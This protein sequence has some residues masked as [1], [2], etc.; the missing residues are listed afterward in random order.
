MILF[1]VRH[2]DPIYNP[3]S[4][5][6]L[7]H[8]QAKALAKRLM[9]HGVDEVY[10]S[11][12]VRATQTA[13]PTAK[14]LKKE[15]HPCE[16][17][18]ESVAWRGFATKNDKGVNTWCF[19]IPKYVELFNTAEIR[20]MGQE[21]HTHPAFA[22]TNFTNGVLNTNQSVDDFLLSLGYR[23]VR[24][25]GYYEV[26]E[27]NPRRIALFAHQGMGMAF[28]SSLLDIPYPLFSTHF[29]LS[30]SSMTVIHFDDEKTDRVVP[31]VL[32]LAN[33]S[34]LYREGLLTGY[35]NRIRF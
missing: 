7:G 1:Y 22:E 27:K 35:N 3:D 24:E 20:A 14:L 8:E 9:L 10:A 31:K 11:T 26:V 5:T 17:A 2:G 28:L 25:N 16:W 33:D 19:Q 29:D 12:S 21:W 15:I 32:Q 4:L 23:H 34:H 18:Q 6:D 13:T 30:H